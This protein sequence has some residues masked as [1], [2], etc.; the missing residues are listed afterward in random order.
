M[1]TLDD[2]VLRILT[3]MYRAG[4][5][6]VPMPSANTPLANVTN[7]EHVALARRLAAAGTVLLVRSRVPARGCSPHLHPPC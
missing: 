4:L 6:D 5:F 1:S 3:P 2:M 7:S